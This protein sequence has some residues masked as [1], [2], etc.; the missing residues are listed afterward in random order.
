MAPKEDMAILE[1]NG[2]LILSCHLRL[3]EFADKH[4]MK[5]PKSFFY[6]TFYCISLFALAFFVSCGAKVTAPL[7]F[8]CPSSE[9]F[10]SNDLVFNM[11]AGEIIANRFNLNGLTTG[12][13]NLSSV[14]LYMTTQNINSITVSIYDGNSSGAPNGGTLIHSTTKAITTHSA[15]PT[16]PVDI[17]LSSPVPLYVETTTGNDYFI[18][19]SPTPGAYSI[20]YTSRAYISQSQIS[21]YNGVTW[22]KGAQFADNLSMA[23]TYAGCSK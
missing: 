2:T 3:F 13:I 23:F 1:Y 16:S 12:S 6:L 22:G 11:G 20:S 8:T 21:M 17:A 19:I 15:S 9:D 5:T 4:S 10:S 7:Q 18:V 14:R